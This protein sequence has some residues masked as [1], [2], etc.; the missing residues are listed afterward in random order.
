MRNRRCSGGQCNTVQ[1]E[2][3]GA[4]QDIDGGAQNNGGEGLTGH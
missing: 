3:S 2:E 1:G 4:V